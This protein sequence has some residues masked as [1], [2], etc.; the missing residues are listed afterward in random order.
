[1]ICLILGFATPHL[2][3]ACSRI[4]WI[5]Y[6]SEVEKIVNYILYQ[7]LSISAS[8]GVIYTSEKRLIGQSVWVYYGARF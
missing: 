1:M 5:K 3:E 8:K 2:W 7:T 4:V 6:D